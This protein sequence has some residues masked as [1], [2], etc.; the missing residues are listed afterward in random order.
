MSK[1][2]PWLDEIP[3]VKE[4]FNEVLSRPRW[5]GLATR[6]K[7]DPRTIGTVFPQ[8]EK[9][10]WDRYNEYEAAVKEK[11]KSKKSLDILENSLRQGRQPRGGYSSELI[12]QH[13]L[14]LSGIH[15]SRWVKYPEAEEGE[16]LDMVIPSKATMYSDP[17]KTVTIS[18]KRRVRERWREVVG[19]AYILREIHRYKGRIVFVT[20]E[21]DLE[22]Y[23]LQS[24]QKLDV[25]VYTPESHSS[26]YA[27]YGVRP[28][29]SLVAD[30]VALME[31]GE[32]ARA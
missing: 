16:Q 31:K 12:F 24:L 3:S 11:W 30:L 8:L 13:L 4:I 25:S 10:A 28:V 18:I 32:L 23:A 20:M 29:T 2:S 22:S 6:I 17:A 1:D 15:S 19:E 14:T 27:E 21:A 9:E 5:K 7:A 26:R